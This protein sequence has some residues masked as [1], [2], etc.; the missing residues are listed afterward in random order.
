MYLNIGLKKKRVYS[1]LWYRNEI[2]KPP[3]KCNEVKRYISFYCDS[4]KESSKIKKN[5]MSIYN[6]KCHNYGKLQ[7]FNFF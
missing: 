3:L 6:K 4:L 5:N 2:F 1:V 7:S